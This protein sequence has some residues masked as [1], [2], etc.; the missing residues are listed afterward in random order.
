MVLSERNASL[1]TLSL[2]IYSTYIWYIYLLIN[3]Y[4]FQWCPCGFHGARDQ[5]KGRIERQQ[6][7]DASV[8]DVEGTFRCT[9]LTLNSPFSRTRIHVVLKVLFTQCYYSNDY[10]LWKRWMFGMRNIYLNMICVWMRCL[11][12]AYHERCVRFSTNCMRMCVCVIWMWPHAWFFN[13]AF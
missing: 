3:T 5:L 12:Y 8:H 13:V 2:S 6:F 1:F 9:M 7:Q 4:F 11:A 10:L